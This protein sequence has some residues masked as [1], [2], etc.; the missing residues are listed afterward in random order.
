MVQ[1]SVSFTSGLILVRGAF[2]LKDALKAIPSAK[3]EPE[4]KAWTFADS[5]STRQGLAAILGDAIPQESSKPVPTVK[6]N[7]TVNPWPHQREAAHSIGQD[8]AFYLHGGMGVGKTKCAVDAVVSYDLRM[9]LVLCPSSVVRVWP[10]EFIKYAAAPVDVLTLDA[11]AGSVT[12]RTK[13]AESGRRMAESRGRP[14]VAV[15]NYEAAWRAPFAA[16]VLEQR[17]DLVVLDEAHRIKS[18]KGKASKW[19][20]K[21]RP[22]ARHMTGLSG[23]PMPHSPIDIFAQFRALEPGIFGTSLTRFRLRY[24]A[25]AFVVRPGQVMDRRVTLAL[26]QDEAF[27][28]AWRRPSSWGADFSIAVQAAQWGLSNQDIVDILVA[29][30]SAHHEAPR[31]YNWF[32]PL[33]NKVREKLGHGTSAIQRWQHLAELREKMDVITMHVGR[34][35]LSLTDAAEVVRHVTLSKAERKAHDE[36]AEDL[37]TEI[38]AGQVTALNALTKLLRLQQATGGFLKTDDDKI[39]NIGSSRADVLA[40]VFEELRDDRLDGEVRH[41]PVVVFCRFHSDLDA[42]HRVALEVTGQDALELS[43]RVNQLAQWQQDGAPPVLAVQIQAGGLGVSMTRACFSVYY[44]VGYSLADLEQAK[45]RVHRPGQE[46]AVTHI[47]LVADDTVDEH[48]YAAIKNKA[49]V[50]EHVLGKLRPKMQG[51]KSNV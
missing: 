45:A 11:G 35:V 1:T 30:A 10:G 5:P 23:T 47:F 42:V 8:F 28:A 9:V 16:W 21:L 44:S 36:L 12:K 50:V 46:R 20:E 37:M 7:T 4:R 48:V 40:E 2:Q 43:G 31:G 17:W 49:E 27:Q 32:I 13:S 19:V 38:D 29:R 51:E 41:E 15:I 34:E 24:E 18:A 14:F 26:E 3:W 22:R 33:L 25:Q 6:L 39:V